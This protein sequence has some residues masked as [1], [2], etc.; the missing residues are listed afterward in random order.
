YALYLWH[1]PLLIFY[2]AWRYQDD[3]SW[4]EGSAILAV[5]VLLAWLTTKYVE[6]P[7]RAG[8]AKRKQS[9]VPPDADGVVA[10]PPF[11]KTRGYRR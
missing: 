5:S 2:L 4:F 9:P 10:R 7:L 11:E 1:W 6:A 8:S 3:V